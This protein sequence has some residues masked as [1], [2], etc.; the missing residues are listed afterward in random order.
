[1]APNHPW[2]TLLIPHLIPKPLPLLRFEPISQTPPPPSSPTTSLL[3]HFSPASILLFKKLFQKHSHDPET[4][5][6]PLPKRQHCDT[7]LETQITP[8]SVITYGFHQFHYDLDKYYL[9]ASS[10]TRIYVQSFM[11]PSP[12]KKSTLPRFE[13]ERVDF[14]EGEGIHF[15][16]D[17]T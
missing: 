11:K 16:K 3:A 12:S 17:C 15:T 14:F 1:M 13:V 4:D 10:L 5:D 9:S 2:P 7:S 8:G 6:D